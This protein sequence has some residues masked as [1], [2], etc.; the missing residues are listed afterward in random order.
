MVSDKTFY[1]S[2]E[3]IV[4]SFSTV[5]D[6]IVPFSGLLITT[7][8]SPLSLFIL[9]LLIAIISKINFIPELSIHQILLVS[10][11]P[12]ARKNVIYCVLAKWKNNSRLEKDFLETNRRITD[13]M[14]YIWFLV[15]RDRPS[16]VERNSHSTLETKII[17]YV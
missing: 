15:R 16:W 7:F 14:K 10:F 11:S 5:S 12:S 17:L 13:L 3:F 8:L 4:K 1:F 2:N 9:M 6:D